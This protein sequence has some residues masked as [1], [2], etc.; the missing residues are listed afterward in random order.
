M[1]FNK[2]IDVYTENETTHKYKIQSY[3]LLKQVVRTYVH[4]YS[5][6]LTGL[7]MAER[8]ASRKIQII[9]NTRWTSWSVHH[10]SFANH[11][12]KDIK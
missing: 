9:N 1:L 8:L 4:T 10:I 7:Q 11:N 12:E 6:I 2:I 3:W 5:I